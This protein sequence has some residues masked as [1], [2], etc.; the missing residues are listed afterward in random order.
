[1]IG[2]KAGILELRYNSD[3]AV[4]AFQ[5]A[6][7][8]QRGPWAMCPACGTHFSLLPK[9]L[10]FAKPTLAWKNA[11]PIPANRVFDH[12]GIS[13][14]L[15]GQIARSCPGC[16]RAWTVG[17]LR[18]KKVYFEGV[19]TDDVSKVLCYKVAFLPYYLGETTLIFDKIVAKGRGYSRIPVDPVT[20]QS[21]S[22]INLTMYG[23]NG[24]LTDPVKI[25]AAWAFL[26]FRASYEAQRILTKVYVDNGSAD[27][28]HPDILRRYGYDA[29]IS[30]VQAEYAQVFTGAL[31]SGVPEPYAPNMGQLYR[32]MNKAWFAIRQLP[33]PNPSAIKYILNKSVQQTSAKLLV[34]PHE[35]GN[36][37]VTKH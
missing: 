4:R 17:Q 15:D 37:G 5:F 26:R 31:Q 16:R 2:E 18:E 34:S 28:L 19:C 20:H 36:S 11:V 22:E 32:E 29:H 12:K 6:W 23:I 33:S 14:P 1:L 25:D 27:S 10:Q 8:L 3:P 24:K 21:R 13:L 7:I 30:T 35:I 9:T